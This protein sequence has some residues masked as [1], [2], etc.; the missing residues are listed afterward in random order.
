MDIGKVG[1][2]KEFIEACKSNPSL[3]HTPSLSF[4]KTYL[5]SLGANIPPQPKTVLV[6]FLFISYF[7]LFTAHCLLQ[8]T[9]ICMQE[10]VVVDDHD[11]IES[12]IELDNTDLVKPDNDPPQKVS[13]ILF[14]LFISIFI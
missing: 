10:P 6:P 12:D 3:L 4:F 7:Q 5:L 14:S 9:C 2:L 13:I 8:N 1:E 11:I